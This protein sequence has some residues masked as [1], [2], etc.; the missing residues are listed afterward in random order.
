LQESDRAYK[1][2]MEKQA[3]KVEDKRIADA[4]KYWN[5]VYDV[6]KNRNIAGYQIPENI[7]ISRNGEKISASPEDFFNY[8]YRVDENGQS[9]YIKDLSQETPESRR[10]DEIL[11]AYL[12]FVGG[13][14]SNLV[15]MAINKATVNKLRFKAKEKST[16][17][18]VTKPTNNNQK[19]DINF[20]Y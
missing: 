10:D 6:I 9:A 18:R 15:D 7:I 3:K 11:R 5:G 17:Y 12:K 13:N 20:S 4:E 19:K 16:S 14:Y 2:E 8:I 1:E